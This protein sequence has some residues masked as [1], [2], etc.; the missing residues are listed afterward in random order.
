LNHADQTV[1][2]VR[3]KFADLAPNELDAMIDEAVTTVR[4]AP[5]PP[6][7]KVR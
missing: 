5:T 4:Q 3:S 1:A 7:L 6:T 2:E